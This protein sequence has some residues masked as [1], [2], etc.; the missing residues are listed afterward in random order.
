MS[1]D[2]RKVHDQVAS[3][4]PSVSL[5]AVSKTHPYEAILEAYG[6]GARLFGENR[7]Q[8]AASSPSAFRRV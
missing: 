6:Q 2:Y 8:E 1:V 7:V 4:S 3:L 5:M